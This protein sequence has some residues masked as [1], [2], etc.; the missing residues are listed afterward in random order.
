[1]T[2][3]A[4]GISLD[5]LIRVKPEALSRE[6]DGEEVILNAATGTYFGLE[7]VG[8]RV[9][10]CIKEGRPPSSEVAVLLEEYD[11][12]ERRLRGDILKLLKDFRKQGLIELD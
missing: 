2:A 4:R 7:A 3:S 9:W 12:D 1:M 5:S 8:A 6:L 10:R 11:V